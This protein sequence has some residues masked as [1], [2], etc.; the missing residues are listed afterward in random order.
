MGLCYA[1]G[2]VP[3]DF[4]CRTADVGALWG[5]RRD[6]QD[7]D[8][9]FQTLRPTTTSVQVGKLE[10]G[11]RNVPEAEAQGREDHRGR[12]GERRIRHPQRALDPRSRCRRFSWSPSTS[13]TCSLRSGPAWSRF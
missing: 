7:R 2:Q 11:K 5:L 10:K 9:A 4:L 8:A 6:Q 3:C 13:L 1:R 12:E